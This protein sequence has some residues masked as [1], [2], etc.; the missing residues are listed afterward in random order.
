MANFYFAV[1]SSFAGVS[2]FYDANWDQCVCPCPD[3]ASQVFC[4]SPNKAIGQTECRN[5]RSGDP[6][7][8]SGRDFKCPLH[9]VCHVDQ[10]VC[11]DN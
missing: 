1:V 9:T 11:E 4:L 8:C 7:N 2:A 10:C 5:V 3:P 6:N